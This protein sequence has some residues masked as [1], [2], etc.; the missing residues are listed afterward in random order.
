MLLVVS[1]GLT[2]P[3][4]AQGPTF[5]SSGNGML[6]GNYYFRH[7]LY[8][9]SNSADEEG[10]TG[11][12]S[13]AT[14][15]Y[16]I[17]T[18]NGSGGYTITGGTVSDSYVD[19]QEGGIVQDGLSCYN[20]GTICTSAQGTPVTG[21]YAISA[22]GFGYILNPITGDYIYGTVSA[23]GVFIG[24][25]T[26]S[27]EAY[28]DLFIAALATPSMTN[29]S[30]SG[31]Y[32]AVGFWPGGGAYAFGEGFYG[33]PLD[34]LG[35]SFQLNPNG[36]GSLGSVSISG[37]A[38]NGGAASQTISGATYSFSNGAAVVTLPSNQN[39]AFF[40]GGP[41]TPE[42]LY[43]SPDG[44]FFFGGSPTTGFDMIVGVKNSGTSNFGSPQTLYY[45]AGIDQTIGS[46]AADF[47]GY[48]GAFNTTSNGNIIFHERLSDE[49]SG[50]YGWTSADTFTPPIAA[51]Y[52]DTNASVQ[53]AVG[54][55]GQVRIGQGIWPYMGLTLG[56]QAPT[57]TPSTSVYLNPTGIV[58]AASFS[59]FTAGVSDGEMVTLFGNNLAASTTSATS[60]PLPT[61]QGLGGVKVLVNGIDAPLNYVSPGQILMNV[62]YEASLSCSSA[63]IDSNSCVA[64]FQVINNGSASNTVTELLN[65]TT[66]G[67][68]TGDYGLGYGYVQHS[69]DYSLVT[70]SNPAQPGETVIAYVSGL[71]TV[72]PFVADGAAAPSS[73]L[74][75]TT[76]GIYVDIGGVSANNGDPVTAVLVPTLS[77]LYQVN[78]AVPSTAAS[79]DQPL[80][81][82]GPD[83][84]N[85]QTLIS[86]ASGGS[87]RHDEAQARP[88]NRAK[89]ASR[90]HACLYGAKAGCKAK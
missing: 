76:S 60:L 67:I 64:Q 18:F 36:S 79:G 27:S 12:I 73:P 89:S 16:G 35:A 23:N 26:E 58:N 87:A 83:S 5:D 11:D 30:F 21:T 49:E 66:P 41:S 1:L 52:T 88:H 51:S 71:G 62:P 57:F 4:A 74:S 80:D 77:G 61:S 14:I 69:A 84:Y 38:G 53:Y 2:L 19:E 39:G 34:T 29:A 33:S 20:A 24:S 44:N 82:S 28:N 17:I 32:S 56:I 46:T 15:I 9:I 75:N 68:F 31:S 7:A 59:P 25:S 70:P 63:Q 55:G 86:I 90:A 45:Q 8:G 54:A 40:L 37:T 22:S 48:Y 10:Y 3:L 43:F 50:T 65:T 42:Y 47:D 85:T 72:S 81:I 6:S 13:E 78:F